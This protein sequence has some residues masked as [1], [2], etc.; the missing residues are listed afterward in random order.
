MHK[1]VLV[2]ALKG[3]GCAAYQFAGLGNPQ[4]PDAMHDFGQVQS[5]DEFHDENRRA[6]DLPGVVCLDDVRVCKPADGLHFA[7]KAG[8]CPAVFQAAAR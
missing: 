2:R 6:V 4:R 3:Q 7:F 1:S 5:V 8:D